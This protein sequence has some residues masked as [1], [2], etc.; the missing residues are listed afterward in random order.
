MKIVD[1][2]AE[3]ICHIELVQADILKTTNE[4][5]ETTEKVLSTT[6]LRS[7]S[8]VL[9]WTISDSDGTWA[10]SDIMADNNLPACENNDCTPNSNPTG[11]VFSTDSATHTHHISV[12]GTIELPD[13]TTKEIDDLSTEITEGTEVVTQ[14][15]FIGGDYSKIS[16]SGTAPNS[17]ISWVN[18]QENPGSLTFTCPSGFGI[19]NNAPTTVPYGTDGTFTII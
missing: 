3:H 17:G 16:S 10:T 7:S 8:N 9:E 12:S 4:L 11:Y 18:D 14:V 15:T 1:N 2:C 13:G 5:G 6:P 19:P